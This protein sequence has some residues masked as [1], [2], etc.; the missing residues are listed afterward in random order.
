VTNKIIFFVFLIILFLT[1]RPLRAQTPGGG[2]Y[3]VEQRYVQNLEWIGDNYTLKYEVVIERNEGGGASGGY[4]VFIREFTEKQSLQVSLPVGKYRYRIIPYDYLEQ[5]G[6]A[7]EWINIEIKPA[8]TVSAETR[9]EDNEIYVPPPVET[10]PLVNETV[11][12][13]TDDSTKTRGDET[14]KPLNLYISAAWTP[15]IPLYGRISEIFENKF[16]P[17]GASVRFGALYNKPRW[18][19]PGIELSMSWYGLNNDQDGDK[20]GVQTG[21]MGVNLVAQ[22]KL[23]NPSMAVT[24]RAG[25]A[26]A[27]QV[28]E[29]NVEDYSYSTG[30]LIPQINIEA[31]FLWFAY[32]KL[33]LEAGIG[34]AH[35]LDKDSN[36]GCLRPWIGVGWQF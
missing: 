26:Y 8:P 3:V 4:K 5:A 22:K 29:I 15:L 7:T 31:S 19:S 12:N 23:P 35:L 25:F 16:Y 11:I 17:T 13:R 28:G 14:E 33:Y 18:F 30:G 2:R 20:I 10:A 21:V 32:K 27:F 9:K 24:I 34:F 1:G 6:I 36:S